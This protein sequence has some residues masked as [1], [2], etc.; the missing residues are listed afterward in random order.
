MKTLMEC[1]YLLLSAL[2]IIGIKVSSMVTDPIDLI[3]CYIYMFDAMLYICLI[4]CY[5]YV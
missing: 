1:P 3:P 2:S 4:P 5:I